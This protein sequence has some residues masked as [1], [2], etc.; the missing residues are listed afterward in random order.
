MQGIGD[1]DLFALVGDLAL[2]IEDAAVG[3]LDLGQRHEL[4]R[5]FRIG[6]GVMDGQ[7]REAVID[8]AQRRIEKD[9]RA[10]QGDQAQALAVAGIARPAPSAATP[11]PA[12]APPGPAPVAGIIRVL[13]PLS[14]KR[15]SRTPATAADAGQDGQ[16]QGGQR[17]RAA[18]SW[19]RMGEIRELGVQFAPP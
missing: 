18:N 4:G 10:H 17:V 2:A 11:A 1:G 7:R 19:K 15:P 9:Q 12:P 8:V 3:G 14:V 5:V 16:D 6:G 13:P